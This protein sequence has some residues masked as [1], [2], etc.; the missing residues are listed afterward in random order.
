MDIWIILGVVAA[1]L[2]AI[3]F[4]SRNAVWGGLT[5]GIIIGFMIVIFSTIGGVV[6]TGLLSVRA[7]F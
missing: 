1:I 5:G 7:Q 4:R 6:L 3:Y 2:L